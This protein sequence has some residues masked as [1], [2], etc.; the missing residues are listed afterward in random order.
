MEDTSSRRRTRNHDGAVV[1][2][3]EEPQPAK[4]AKATTAHISPQQLAGICQ[5]AR[6]IHLET[7]LNLKSAVVTICERTGVEFTAA[8]MQKV[9]RW[10]TAN[11]WEEGAPAQSPAHGPAATAAAAADQPAEDQPDEQEETSDEELSP[12][13]LER[14]QEGH[15]ELMAVAFTDPEV[16]GYWDGHQ[17]DRPATRDRIQGRYRHPQTGA[18]L[19]FGLKLVT[20]ARRARASAQVARGSVGLIAYEH[21][22][23]YF[24]DEPSETDAQQSPAQHAR[25][26]NSPGKSAASKRK[27]GTGQ[28]GGAS[29]PTYQKTKGASGDI[30]SRFKSPTC[31]AVFPVKGRP[32]VASSRVRTSVQEILAKLGAGFAEVDDALDE[33]LG[34]WDA[35]NQLEQKLAVETIRDGLVT[36]LKKLAPEEEDGMEEE[37]DSPAK[38]FGSIQMDLIKAVLVNVLLKD[39]NDFVELSAY[40][41]GSGHSPGKGFGG[42]KSK[43]RRIDLC[44][45]K[46]GGL[47]ESALKRLQ[48]LA[49]LISV[50]CA[51][52]STPSDTAT[53]NEDEAPEV[54]FEKSI[55][56]GVGHVLSRLVSSA[57]VVDSA[58]HTQLQFQLTKAFATARH[59]RRISGKTYKWI[60]STVKAMP[61]DVKRI[62]GK[63]RRL[64]PT[65]ADVTE[66]RYRTMEYSRSGTGIGMRHVKVPGN[67]RVDGHAAVTPILGDEGDGDTPRSIVSFIFMQPAMREQ[68][69][70]LNDR[71]QLADEGRVV[72]VHG[73]PLTKGLK[74]LVAELGHEEKVDYD[75]TVHLNRFGE[76]GVGGRVGLI[77]TTGKRL[78]GQ[79]RCCV[80]I[81]CHS[82]AAAVVYAEAVNTA[83][84]QSRKAYLLRSWRWRSGADAG[85]IEAGKLMTAAGLT[86]ESP[87]QNS[88]CTFFPFAIWPGK[89]DA[90]CAF[91][92]ADGARQDFIR[93]ERNILMHVSADG[94]CTFYQISIQGAGDGAHLRFVQRLGS[95]SSHRPLAC[96]T[97]SSLSCTKLHPLM[98]PHPSKTTLESCGKK[99]KTISFTL[100]GAIAAAVKATID[101]SD[102]LK[103]NIQS[104]ALCK[105]ITSAQYSPAD[106]DAVRKTKILA[107]Y[108][109]LLEEATDPKNATKC[110]PGL[111]QIRPLRLLIHK[112]LSPHSD[113]RINTND[114]VSRL[115]FSMLL[116]SAWNVAEVKHSLYG[117]RS[118]AAECIA[119]NVRVGEDFASAVMLE[120]A[121]V[122]SVVCPEDGQPEFVVT[123]H[124]SKED[125]THA[126]NITSLLNSLQAVSGLLSKHMSD[127]A[128]IDSDLSSLEANLEEVGGNFVNGMK[129]TKVAHESLLELFHKHHGPAFYTEMP[130]P[131]GLH[132]MIRTMEKVV[133]LWGLDLKVRRGT[134]T[135]AAAA[136]AECK[137]SGHYSMDPR[138]K[139]SKLKFSNN[140]AKE[141]VRAC[142]QADKMIKP[143]VLPAT[144]AG[145]SDQRH[146]LLTEIA[147][148]FPLMLYRVMTDPKVDTTYHRH[149]R[150]QLGLLLRDFGFGLRLAFSA[151]W[152]DRLLGI[153]S[154]DILTINV[155]QHFLDGRN[156]ALAFG[157][158]IEASVQ[159]MK[160]WARTLFRGEDRIFTL[161]QQFW[162]ALW[163]ESEDAAGLKAKVDKV[164]K[165]HEKKIV[166]MNAELDACT[167]LFAR[168]RAA[169]QHQIAKD[170][171]DSLKACRSKAVKPLDHISK[172]RDDIN[173]LLNKAG[174]ENVA[175]WNLWR[176]TG[177]SPYAATPKIDAATKPKTLAE[178]QLVAE[179]EI[180]RLKPI[181]AADPIVD[182][183]LEVE[184][185]GQRI[186]FTGE[187]IAGVS[188]EFACKTHG[189]P[190]TK[191]NQAEADIL[192]DNDRQ[193]NLDTEACDVAFGAR[194]MRL[195]SALRRQA[196]RDAVRLRMEAKVGVELTA[197][198]VDT[199]AVLFHP[200]RPEANNTPV[201]DVENSTAVFFH[202]PTAEDEYSVG[203]LRVPDTLQ[204]ADSYCIFELEEKK[205]AAFDPRNRRQRGALKGL[206]KCTAYQKQ[207]NVEREVAASDI[208][209]TCVCREDSSAAGTYKIDHADQEYAETRACDH[210]ETL[211]PDADL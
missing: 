14:F 71:I 68:L 19:R 3:S 135:H 106:N 205:P 46:T 112:P 83:A 170:V 207:L 12:V 176:E 96:S 20:K 62:F 110:R 137:I 28:G 15:K 23:R 8:I 158:V 200:F 169:T 103:W 70:D 55:I 173:H 80:L 107:W 56:F 69:V 76:T 210:N 61:G 142:E 84:P 195:T 41:L 98:T 179:A 101:T 59:R 60:L 16:S 197:D 140:Q 175:E 102:R 132:L 167:A 29:T 171:L 37:D 33:L 162:G 100:A 203:V 24:P 104:A 74:E 57:L 168:L 97:L 66:E 65:A 139:T 130:M 201:G 22:P 58:A 134:E 35:L 114:A 174:D 108:D 160:E 6:A 39:S 147:F 94:T 52:T 38:T 115:S 53:A 75:G 189:A 32:G 82:A 122:Q 183:L 40:L 30:A 85:A 111:A 86:P 148:R 121:D 95:P 144:I 172:V 184:S 164:K 17:H 117:L 63:G 44:E 31:A 43:A 155:P 193:P 194:V 118:A 128:R 93:L 186:Y 45:R 206:F 89:D 159:E 91:L 49:V 116:N 2:Q 150:E 127:M 143:C 13:Y 133:S 211:D 21:L 88:L 9:R 105:L 99:V 48:N 25:P 73:V 196:R 163:S 34:G 11:P 42:T 181:I 177:D 26:T 185:L 123:W 54:G 47:S 198:N 51:G 204:P 5:Q 190:V 161:L 149:S 129:I 178:L 180:E 50:V 209:Y 131:D 64:F 208:V 27:R 199:P 157:Q 151:L 36:V 182:G 152:D 81:R 165:H 156:T 18:R 191:S 119:A 4:K 7:S 1:A 202:E 90:D 166:D 146:A 78:E 141:Y 72:V 79:D 136:L 192:R 10:V 92:Y 187:N 188:R 87:L 67:R 120:A 109:L 138:N 113:E 77:S 154:I 153:P 125:T 124:D 126:I 145:P